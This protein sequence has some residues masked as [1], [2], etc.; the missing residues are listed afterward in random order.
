MQA[1]DEG[2]VAEANDRKPD[3]REIKERIQELRYRKKKY[4]TCQKRLEETGKN[5]ISTHFKL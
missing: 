5:E 4:E 3:A 2:D 1:L